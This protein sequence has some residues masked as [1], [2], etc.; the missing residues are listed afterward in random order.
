MTTT[1]TTRRAFFGL[2]GVAIAAIAITR[3]NPRTALGDMGTASPEGTPMAMGGAAAAWMLITNDGTEDDRLVGG[4]SDIAKSTEIHEMKLVDEVMQMSPLPDGLPIPAGQT[5]EL[6]PGGYHIMFLGL[7]QDV[8]PNTT[9][10]LTLTFE[11]AGEVELEV[12]VYMSEDA[13]TDSLPDDA[14]EPVTAGSITIT[15]YWTRMAPM[16]TD[17][18]PEASPEATPDK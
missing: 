6:K 7:T 12:P 2:G 9:Y 5:V 3:S 16:L 11:K 18:S 13:H 4:E 15:N 17:A 10:K 1:I 14:P 8:L